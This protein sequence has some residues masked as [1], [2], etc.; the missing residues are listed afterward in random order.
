[1]PILGLV[2]FLIAGAINASLTFQGDMV[3][4]QPKITIRELP[5]AEWLDGG[6][7][8]LP[9]RRSDVFGETEERIIAQSTLPPDTLAGLLEKDGWKRTAP[10]TPSDLLFFLVPNAPLDKFVPLPLMH[11]GRLP[12]LTLIHADGDPTRRVVLRVWPSDIVVRGEK[13]SHPLALVSL[14]I[15]RVSHPYDALTILSDHPAGDNEQASVRATLTH[16]GTEGVMVTMRQGDRR[17][18]VLLSPN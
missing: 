18:I 12:D 14:T 17:P 3:R 16:L 11:G 6:W 1:M 8:H 13:E 2:G 10:F 9:L 15:E 5:V 4:Y 7:Q